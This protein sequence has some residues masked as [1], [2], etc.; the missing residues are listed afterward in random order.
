[1]DR[2]FE[3]SLSKLKDHE[4][5]FEFSVDEKF[6]ERFEYSRISAAAV[7]FISF[8]EK[9]GSNI[10]VN[11]SWN[12]KVREVCDR[13]TENIFIPVSGENEVLIKFSDDEIE[14]DDEDIIFIPLHQTEFNMGQL[15]YDFLLTS[16][17]MKVSCDIKGSEKNCNEETLKNLEKFNPETHHEDD[18]RWDALKGMID[19]E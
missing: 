14:S 19:E 3:I 16:I 13:C 6:F 1:M 15:L 2:A 18:D 11:T 17:P 5:R 7:E 8:F 12:G 4:N 10:R 9:A